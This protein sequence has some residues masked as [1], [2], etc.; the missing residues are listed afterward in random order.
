MKVLHV[1]PSLGPL[2]GGPSF[3]V[4]AMVRG[5]ARAGIEVHIATTDDNGPG[6]LDVPLGK[7]VVQ[8][9]VTH[10]YF[11]RQVQLYAV[12]LPLTSWLIRHV[13][14]Y[15]LVHIH[16]LFSYATLPATL[17]AIL[18]HKP[19]IIRPLGTLNRWGRQ[20]RRP[21][22]KKLSFHM[23]ERHILARANAVHFTSEQEHNQAK[24][25]NIPMK[26]VIVPLG[27]T[28]IPVDELP[29]PGMFRTRYPHF[30]G[31]TLLMFLGRL[32]RIKGLELLLPAFAHV[33]ESRPDVALILAGKGAQEYEDYLKTMVR[34]LGIE[35]DVAFPGFLSGEQKQAALV[36]SDMF[37][38]PSSFESFSIATIEAMDAGLPVIIS[39]QVGIAHEVG[40]AGAGI[41]VPCNQER[42]ADAIMQLVTDS[43]EQQRL[44]ANGR[45]LVQEHFSLDA[46]TRALV[47]VYQKIITTPTG[48]N[49]LETV[50]FL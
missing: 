50:Q 25:L 21:R 10:W 36:D 13:R 14:N 24:E 11:R 16:A 7:P 3:S 44:A 34:S 41:V 38:L 49:H 48:S 4:P 46:T 9:G 30:A 47:D 22:L 35:Q 45:K 28:P 33:R 31:K 23:L 1:I 18:N 15:D 43:S 6:H 2:R 20:Q 12:S 40:R 8:D 5:L 26:P 17:C 27:I 29:A 37:I 19:Y 39:D 42:L 32:D